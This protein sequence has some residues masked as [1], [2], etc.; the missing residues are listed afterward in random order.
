MLI[1]CH[2]RENANYMLKVVKEYGI[3]E[4]THIIKKNIMGVFSRPLSEVLGLII[5]IFWWYSFSL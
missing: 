5:N 1:P 3:M 2:F 4:E